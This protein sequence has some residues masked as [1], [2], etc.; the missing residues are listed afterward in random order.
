MKLTDGLF[1]RTVSGGAAL[2]PLSPTTC[3]LEETQAAA[4]KYQREIFS[5]WSLNIGGQRTHVYTPLLKAESCLLIRFVFMLCKHIQWQTI[6][7]SSSCALSSLRMVLSD[8]EHARTRLT[9]A[10]VHPMGKLHSL[11]PGCPTSLINLINHFF[12]CHHHNYGRWWRWVI[13]SGSLKKKDPARKHTNLTIISA[14]C[15][16]WPELCCQIDDA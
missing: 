6:K 16:D 15:F 10:P 4:A 11:L 3:L 9:G 7:I 8:L 12:H 13:I 1:Y 5:T 2:L 14:G